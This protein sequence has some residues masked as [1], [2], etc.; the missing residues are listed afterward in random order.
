LIHMAEYNTV[1]EGERDSTTY[2]EFRVHGLFRDG[3]GCPPS[4][5]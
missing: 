1:Q 4:M 3:A 2:N 5:V